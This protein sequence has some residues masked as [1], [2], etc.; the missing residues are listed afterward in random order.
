MTQRSDWPR[1]SETAPWFPGRVDGVLAIHT[2]DGAFIWRPDA[3]KD[4]PAEIVEAD[5]ALGALAPDLLAEVRRLWLAVRAAVS[6]AHSGAHSLPW[7]N[8]GRNPCDLWA[9]DGRFLGTMDHESDARLVVAAVNALAEVP[10]PPAETP[11][12]LAE[13]QAA[14][15]RAVLT[16]ATEAEQGRRHAGE[17]ALEAA[18]AQLRA[19]G[20]TG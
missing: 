20:F 1:P 8:R 6:A 17:A 18:A 5:V 2:R 9:G 3:G 15:A 19:A 12:P 13:A 4:V 16:W 11:D 14:A 7:D 10:E